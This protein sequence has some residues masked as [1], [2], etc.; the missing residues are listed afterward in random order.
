MQKAFHLLGYPSN[1]SCSTSN[2]CCP[3]LFQALTHMV[4]TLL[5]M[6]LMTLLFKN[7]LILFVCVFQMT[8]RD[9]EPV[10]LVNSSCSCVAGSGMCNHLVALLYQTA[11]YSENLV[12]LLYQT[13]HYSERECLLSLMSFHAPKRSRSGI[14]HK[15]WFGSI[16][17]LAQCFST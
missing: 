9:S 1:C 11:H 12:A 7:P 16:K 2:G 6:Y 3:Y 14:N 17:Y 5:L 4:P 15:Q 10:V 13:A 8:L